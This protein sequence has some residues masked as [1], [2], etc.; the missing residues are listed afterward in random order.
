[1]ISTKNILLQNFEKSL[2]D[3]IHQKYSLQDFYERSLVVGTP[4]GSPKG[5]LHRLF[6]LK[7]IIEIHCK[8][9][10]IGCSLKI[11]FYRSSRNPLTKIFT[12]NILRGFAPGRPRPYFGINSKKYSLQDFYERSV[13]VG[14]PKGSPKGSLC[15]PFTLKYII[16]IHC[17]N[18]SI[19]CSLKIFSG[20]SP[21]DAPDPTLVS[22]VKKYYLQ[23]FYERSLVVGTPKGSPKG[24]PHRLFTLK[25]I[26]EIHCKNTSIQ[27]SC[28]HGNCKNAYNT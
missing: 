4:S 12:Q 11:L 18:T 15:R 10:S 14:T 13:V 28:F 25:Y 26:I 5:S 3:D 23:D 6:P 2:N 19:G 16:E 7:Y 9:T 20:A 21:P 1:M 24:S 27:Y 8:N 17:K 22:T